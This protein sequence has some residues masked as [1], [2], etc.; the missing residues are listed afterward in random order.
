MNPPISYQGNKRKELNRIEKYEPKE[1]NLMVDV[2]GGGG[3]VSLFYNNKYKVHYNDINKGLT[4]LFTTIQDK[5]KTEKLIEDIKNTKQ[6]EE[7]YYKI[8]DG[9]ANALR[10]L[11]ISKF[12]FR[13]VINRRLPNIDKEKNFL[14][15]DLSFTHLLSYH[16]KL[17]NFNVTNKSYKDI[18]SEYKDN[19]NVF[20][21]LDPPYQTRS[22]NTYGVIFDINDIIYIRKFF[23]ECKCKIMLHID[24]TG[25]TR[26]TFNKFYKIGYPVK[27]GSNSSYSVYTKYHLIATNY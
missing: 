14:K 9:E 8:F 21:Y 12:C 24:Y 27:Y 17:K 6:D 5:N 15:K 1:F 4:D 18:L 3:S 25:Y 19:E 7:T 23:D 10:M 22:A 2:F 11:Y 20:L 26:E 16:D 13:G